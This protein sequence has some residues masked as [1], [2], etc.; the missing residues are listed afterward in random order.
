VAGSRARFSFALPQPYRLREI[1]AFHSRDPEGLADRAEGNVIRKGLLVDGVPVEM[2]ITLGSDQA[3]CVARADGPVARKRGGE[4]QLIARNLLGLAIDPAPFEQAFARDPVIG[5]VIARQRGLRI[6]EAA[7][8][9][10]AITWAIIGQQ[11]NLPFAITLRRTFVRHA[12]RQH[13]SG[14]WC[15]PDAHAVA[16]VDPE[17]LGR[18]KFSRAKAKT[19]VRIST[20]IDEG[21]LTLDR[22]PEGDPEKTAAALLAVKGI[23]PWT[24][25]YALLRGLSFP[26][27]SLHGDVAIRTALHRLT[28]RETRPTIREAQT[29]LERYKPYRSMAAAH[30]WASL[31][32]LDAPDSVLTE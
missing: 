9:F 32:P 8:P 10:E 12:G 20:L 24:V 19:L 31:H 16:Q 7:T 5:A 22:W 27:C 11:I 15:Y 3:E 21:K 14:L 17:D 28:G 4:L 25:N 26:D 29:L 2:K 1:L 18:Q 6:P 30:L 13:S 23:G